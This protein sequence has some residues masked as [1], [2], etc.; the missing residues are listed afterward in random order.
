M[1][2]DETIPVHLRVQAWESTPENEGMTPEG[3]HGLLEEVL[4]KEEWDMDPYV[5][6]LFTSPARES[7][8][9]LVASVTFGEEGEG[10]SPYLLLPGIVDELVSQPPAQGMA[11]R[12]VSFFVE[13]WLYEMDTDRS[14]QILAT[15]E[16]YE[17]YKR[18]ADRKEAKTIATVDIETGDQIHSMLTRGKDTAYNRREGLQEG[19]APQILDE[20]S[21]QHRARQ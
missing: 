20:I 9:V 19:N 18:T 8:L 12:A 21:S 4:T 6:V 3:L 2:D 1:P 15:D 11:L 16:S 14:T 7:Q 13:A 5:A 10:T 17:E